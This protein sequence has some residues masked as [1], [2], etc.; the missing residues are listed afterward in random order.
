MRLVRLIVAFQRFNFTEIYEKT[1]VD[2]F[3]LTRRPE[4][5]VLSSVRGIAKSPPY[6]PR[7][8]G[9][10]N[11]SQNVKIVFEGIKTVEVLLISND[12]LCFLK[13]NKQ[14]GNGGWSN[15]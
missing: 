6:V 4:S 10:Q 13:T 9:T 7:G 8:T 3:P 12:S 2:L 1:I 11:C 5:T 15:P 14:E